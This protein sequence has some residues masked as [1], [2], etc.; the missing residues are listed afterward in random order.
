MALKVVTVVCVLVALVSGQEKPNIIL[1]F[2]DDLGW[3]DL[4]CYGHPTSTTPNLDKMAEG[5]LKFM[6]FYSSAPLCSPSRASLLTGRYQ[7]RTGIW[8]GVLMCGGLGGLPLNET[9]IAAQLKKAGYGTGMVG[10]WHLGVGLNEQYLPTKHGFDQ[11]TGLPYSHDMCPYTICFYPDQACDGHGVAGATPCPLYKDEKIVQQPANFL[12]LAETYSTAATGFIHEM[13]G[14][15]QPFFL[16]MAF[17]HTHHPQ[18]ASKMFTNSTIRGPFGD[19]LAELDWQ[20]GQIFDAINETGISQNTFVFFTSDNGPAL[21]HLSRGGNGGLLRCGKA[22]TYEGGMREP[23]IAWWPGKIKPGRTF[24][25]AATVDLFPT[26]SRLVDIPIPTDRIID[27]VDMSPILFED[28]ESNRESYIYYPSNPSPN[29]GIFA[30]RHKEYKAHYYTKGGVYPHDGPDVMCRPSTKETKHDPPLLFNLDYD[31]GELN[32]LNTKESPYKEILQTINEIKAK[33]ESTV[34]WTESEMNKGAS[35]AA[36]P[37]AK[38]G[39]TPFPKCCSTTSD[40]L[41]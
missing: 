5:G 7:S 37:C 3:G 12:T 20:V 35:N 17:Q 29:I 31:P 8:P 6:N 24:E 32:P 9:T 41:N 25:M 26:I 33:F 14:K 2:A 15:K 13:A 10:K 23:A 38:P 21:A 11:Y 40:M 39:C 16:Y 34:V 18:F 1:L 27:G 30:V 28:K 19:S 4:G 36:K 22:T